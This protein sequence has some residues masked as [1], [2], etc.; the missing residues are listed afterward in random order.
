M[1]AVVL[2]RTSGF[3]IDVHYSSRIV[4][5]DITFSSS[6][7]FATRVLLHSIKRR[8][9]VRAERYSGLLS[10]RLRMLAEGFGC[11]YRQLLF[12]LQRRK[13]SYQYFVRRELLTI[14]RD[15]SLC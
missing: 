2:K 5:Y 7:I 1:V 15:A 11:C 3:S 14:K 4:L 8:H 12:T 13:C 9:L 6:R 10:C